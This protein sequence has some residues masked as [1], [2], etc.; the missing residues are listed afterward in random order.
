MLTIFINDPA[1][2]A[3]LNVEL[4]DQNGKTIAAIPAGVTVAV[5]SDD[6]TIAT[7]MLGADG[8]TG[9]V[10]DGTK[11]GT[12]NLNLVVTGAPSGNPLTDTASVVAHVAQIL[13]SAR[14]VDPNA[15]A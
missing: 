7:M 15:T 14:F 9:T 8:L 13:T 4:L 3:P 12:T 6:P 2:S 10:T 1:T 5:T 11:D